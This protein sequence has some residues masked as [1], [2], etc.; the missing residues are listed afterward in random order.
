MV[1]DSEMMSLGC[2]FSTELSNSE[3]NRVMVSRLA[4]IQWLVSVMA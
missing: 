3:G 1:A 4:E 2:A